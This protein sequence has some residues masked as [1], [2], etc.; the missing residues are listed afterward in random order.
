MWDGV[1]FVK[2]EEERSKGLEGGDFYVG[3]GPRGRRER[4]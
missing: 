1:G 3:E 2:E 4:R